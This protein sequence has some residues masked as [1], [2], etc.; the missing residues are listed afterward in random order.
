MLVWFSVEAAERGLV[1]HCL[2]SIAG[3]A[4]LVSVEGRASGSAPA[5]PHTSHSSRA[6]L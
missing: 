1:K 6:A 5:P 3:G 4:G 2:P